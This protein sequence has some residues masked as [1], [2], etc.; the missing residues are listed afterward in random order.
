MNLQD[1]IDHYKGII[2][3]LRKESERYRETMRDELL[4]LEEELML[5]VFPDIEIPVLAC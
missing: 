4:E 1:G 2:P 3:K 5:I